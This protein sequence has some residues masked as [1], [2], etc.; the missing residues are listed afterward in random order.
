MDSTAEKLHERLLQVENL[1]KTMHDMQKNY[2]VQDKWPQTSHSNQPF[3]KV[4]FLLYIYY[5]YSRFNENKSISSIY[6]HKL[7]LIFENCIIFNFVDM[8][9]RFS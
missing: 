5:Y 6:V 3:N 1:V 2:E 9:W 7:K 8:Y 4:L